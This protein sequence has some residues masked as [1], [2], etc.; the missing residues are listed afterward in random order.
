MLNAFPEGAVFFLEWPLWARLALI[1]GGLLVRPP[2][3]GFT[4]SDLLQTIILTTA[5]VVKLRNWAK[6]RRLERRAAEEQAERGEMTL[7]NCLEED[8]P[9]GIR[10]LIEDPEVEG[11]WNARTVT[12]LHLDGA[13]SDPPSQLTSKLIKYSSTS[14]T[15]MRDTMDIGLAS[16]DAL[17]PFT[18][19]TA[20]ID[21]PAEASSSRKGKTVVISYNGP[22]LRSDATEAVPDVAPSMTNDKLNPS[23]SKLQLRPIINL[24]S[25]GARKF[26]IGNGQRNILGHKRADAQSNLNPL[27]RMEAHRRFHVAESG[28]LLPRDRRLTDMD[29]TPAFASSISDSEDSDDSASR[30]LSWPPRNGSINLGKQFSRRAKRMEGP[31]PVPFRAFLESLP[32]TKPPPS[33]WTEK[34]QARLDAKIL[35]SPKTSDTSSKASLHTP[36]SSTSSTSATATTSPPGSVSIANTRSRKVNDGFEILP[37]GTLEKGPRVKDFGTGQGESEMKKMPRKL[38]KRSRSSSG[39]RRSSIEGRRLSSDMFPLPIF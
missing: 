30:A 21:L 22:Y 9:F 17:T 24:P 3:F 36:S 8:I 12:A 25:S 14:S 29:L 18:E 13:R 27:E 20:V 23:P 38:Q 31:R 33:A 16:P 32:T 35:P 5:F 39:S 10:A 11:V 1:L 34:T 2:A 15:S 28:Q 26:V 19:S 7:V 6:D 4:P 37:A